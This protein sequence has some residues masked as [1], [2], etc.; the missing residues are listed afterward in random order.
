M[1][2]NVGL[3]V[4][5]HEHVDGGDQAVGFH[6]VGGKLEVLGEQLVM[7]LHGVLG[8]AVDASISE[9]D[10]FLVVGELGTVVLVGFDSGDPEGAGPSL[11][12]DF[13]DELFLRCNSCVEARPSS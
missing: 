9:G 5:Y 4:A 8:Y 1:I 2:I 6:A 11:D 12:D 7:V 10:G 3:R 13:V